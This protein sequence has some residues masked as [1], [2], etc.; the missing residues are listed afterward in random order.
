MAFS[1]YLANDSLDTGFATAYM[2]LFTDNPTAAGAGTEASGGSYA[3]QLM[4]FAAAASGSTSTD[5]AITFTVNAATYTHYA[6]FDAVSGGNML[7]YGKLN[8]DAGI[9]VSVADTDIDFASGDVTL[10]VTTSL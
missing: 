3:R 4:S 10:N 1:T 8:D 6:I 5:A 2:A 7:E 9:E